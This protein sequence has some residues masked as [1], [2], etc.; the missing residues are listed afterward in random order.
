MKCNRVW[1]II[2]G[3]VVQQHLAA[4]AWYDLPANVKK[5]KCMDE[6]RQFG[7]LT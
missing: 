5:V 4:E 1:V 2:E 7:S 3:T 6:L